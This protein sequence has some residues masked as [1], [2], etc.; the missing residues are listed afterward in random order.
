[1]AS[2]TTKKMPAFEVLLSEREAVQLREMLE[3]L[4]VQ[5]LPTRVVRDTALLEY[6]LDNLPEA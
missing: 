4:S 5:A 1:M 3:Y 2:V 6:L